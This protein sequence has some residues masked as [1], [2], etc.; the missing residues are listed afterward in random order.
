[1]S[2]KHI[3][4]ISNNMSLSKL[5]S[6]MNSVKCPFRRVSYFTNSQSLLDH[7]ANCVIAKHTHTQ[8]PNIFTCSMF[9]I[10]LHGSVN[11]IHHV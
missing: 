5:S 2:F 3:L 11:A 9:N 6:S 8:S 7:F 4:N 10:S 1:M